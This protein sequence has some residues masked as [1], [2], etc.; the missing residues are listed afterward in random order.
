M[1]LQDQVL[2]M[3]RDQLGTIMF[4]AVF[5]FIGLA[6]FFLAAVRRRGGVRIFVWLG[7]WSGSWGGG[8]ASGSV[9][10]G[11]YR[12]QDSGLRIED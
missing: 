12:I 10:K 6:F 3:L 4:G 7:I 1:R 11:E 9:G 2:P 8:F 5:L